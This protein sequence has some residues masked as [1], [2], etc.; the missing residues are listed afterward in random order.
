M[1]E[2]NFQ[3][4]ESFC[5]INPNDVKWPEVEATIELVSSKMGQYTITIISYLIRYVG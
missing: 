1:W 5:W 3:E 4:D 2:G